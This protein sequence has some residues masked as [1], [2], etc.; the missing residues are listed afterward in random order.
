LFEGVSGAY[1]KNL[2][3]GKNGGT[4]KKLKAGGDPHAPHVYAERGKRA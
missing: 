2:E 3:K 1:G 4:Q